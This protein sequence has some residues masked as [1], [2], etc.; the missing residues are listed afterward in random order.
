MYPHGKSLTCA[1]PR[2]NRPHLHK[3]R[4]ESRQMMLLQLIHALTVKTSVA[5]VHQFVT[6]DVRRWLIVPLTLNCTYPQPATAVHG[7]HTLAASA[8]DN[9][10]RFIDTGSKCPLLT[11]GVTTMRNAGSALNTS[12]AA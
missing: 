3:N 2:K 12:T 4:R 1:S 11:S 7:D 6:T 10:V 9:S 8:E 5:P